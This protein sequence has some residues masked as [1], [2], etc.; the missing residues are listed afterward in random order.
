[1]STYSS[2]QSSALAAPSG[3]AVL[4]AT[5]EPGRAL[6]DLLEPLISAGT[7]AI[8]VVDDA[9]S[10]AREW[11]LDRLALEPT[12]HVMRHAVHQGRGAALKTGIQYFVEHLPHYTGLVTVSTDGEYAVE[13]VVRMA[14]ALHRS[15]KLAIVAAREFPAGTPGLTA[16]GLPV[17]DRLLRLVFRVFTGIAVSDVQTHLRALPTGLL[18]RLL[19]IPGNRFDYEL[20]ALL[21]IARSGYPLAEHAVAPRPE[22]RGVDPEF[23]PLGDSI[24]MLRALMNCNPVDPFTMEH[25]PDA[26]P[27]HTE[28]SSFRV[29]GAKQTR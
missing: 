23:R 24:S 6:L 7:A 22:A 11:L 9:S 16:A 27:G 2:P 12:V 3:V 20:A 21:H 10:H 17:S 18:P 29:G 15:P 14:R 1:M 4:V 13:D 28:S 25:A 8:I 5:Y 26:A 19:R